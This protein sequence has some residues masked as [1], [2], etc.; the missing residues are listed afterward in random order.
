LKKAGR[1]NKKSWPQREKRKKETESCRR[2]RG[3]GENKC[4]D[5]QNGM[6]H[7]EEKRGIRVI[8][9]Q[10]AEKKTMQNNAMR[11]SP[12]LKEGRSAR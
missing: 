7:R 4:C 1:C 11:K 2:R 8:N 10:R 9:F 5:E 3:K 6:A 12:R